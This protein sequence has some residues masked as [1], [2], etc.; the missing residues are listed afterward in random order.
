MRP[1]LDDPKEYALIKEIYFKDNSPLFEELEPEERLERIE[2]KHRQ[3]NKSS[4]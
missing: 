4:R 3:T 2:A 1:R